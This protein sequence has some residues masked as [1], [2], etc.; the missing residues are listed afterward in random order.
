M[1]QTAHRFHVPVMGIGYTLDTPIKIARYGIS[2]VISI[3]QDD[4]IEK[5]RSY[6]SRINQISY[7]PIP[8]KDKEH[9][10]KRIMA[11]LNLVN[12][13][14]NRDFDL[15]KQSPAELAKYARLL[16]G[17]VSVEDLQ[18]QPE[19][20]KKGSIDVNIMTKLDRQASSDETVLTEACAALKGYAESELNSSLV[21]SAGLNPR[22]FAFMQ[23]FSDFYPDAFGQIKKKII[24]K[25]SDFRSAL[26]QG[27]MLAKK[28]L[29]VYEYR[30][31]SGLNC[32]GHTFAT[33][34][35]L[36][37]PIL[38]EF[39]KHRQS[40]L[41]EQLM[42][43]QEDWATRD[44][45]LSE[46]LQRISV[47][48]GLGTSR[49]REFME[50]HYGMDA[51][52]WGTPLLLVPEATSIDDETLNELINAK[53][54][55]IYNSGISPLGVRF[56]T[57]RN[58][59]GEKVKRARIEA[60]KPGS[61]CVRKHLAFDK[62]YNSL[63]LCTA[64]VSFQKKKIKEL[65][66]QNLSKEAHKEAFDQIT[67]KECICD[68]LAVSFLKKFNLM[69]K[70]NNEGV[71]VCPG[72]NLAYFDRSY[73]LEEMVGHIYGKVQ[74]L[75]MDRPHVFIKELRLYIDYYEEIWNA[76]VS[77]DMENRKE[78]NRLQKF[79]DNLF[80]GIDYYQN[81]VPTMLFDN[82]IEKD[83]FLNVLMSLR[84]KLQMIDDPALVNLIL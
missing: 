9:R 40:M 60:G 63:G 80:L 32:G 34:G 77:G 64:S 17:N 11:Y 70:D 48:G 65:N 58:N 81:L 29:F 4:V 82:E 12:E 50:S 25:V 69:G 28:G 24:L 10:S 20:L 76:F 62:T 14:V 37:G 49:E 1:V 41:A 72:P 26:L 23:E 53:E 42:L 75:N 30:I 21:L 38:E 54:G 46:P 79:R 51:T 71:S 19:I 27:K 44:V 55:D 8:K 6:Y 43:C 16:P 78:E 74:V 18:N 47:Q 84:N 31:E 22:L 35:L 83:K 57:I 33:D 73:S 67:Q 5:A 52:G 66:Q 2:S 15:L 56:S 39:K 36:L 45:Q 68:G 7:I 59:S 61:P 13:L 3:V